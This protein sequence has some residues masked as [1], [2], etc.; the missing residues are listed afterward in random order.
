MK[1]VIIIAITFVL[2]IPIPVFAELDLSNEKITS[3]DNN[4]ILQFTDNIVRQF[5]THI[6]IIPNIEYGIINLGNIT[7]A[8]DNARV[9]VLGNSFTVKNDYI[10][11]YA[12]SLGNDKFRINT[13]IFTD[14]G[15]QKNTF[16]TS[17]SEQPISESEII[18][19]NPVVIEEKTELHYITDQYER[20]YN[21]SNY[22]LFVK[23]FDKA[24]YSGNDFQSFQG[25]ISGVKVSAAIVDPD[26]ELKAEISGLSEN[27][28]FK[29][30][31]YVPENLWTKGWYTV[32]MIIE[33][34][35][36]SYPEQL[37]F[38]VY[39]HVPSSGSS[40]E[41]GFPEGGGGG[42]G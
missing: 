30:T 36:K 9:N 23:T 42:G 31:V 3:T 37:T 14:S 6:E 21:K 13:Y 27:G 17:I 41:E 33:H 34:D 5:R 16:I 18:P 32:D 7:L 38:Y 39:G 19:Q 4:L 2:L 26:G 22:K 1:P 25:T 40:E 20:V 12:K 10:A 8:L 35:E 28:L 29:G 15:L 11:L 24:I